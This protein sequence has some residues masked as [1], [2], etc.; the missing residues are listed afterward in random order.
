M[1][2][3]IIM[4]VQTAS[5]VSMKFVESVLLGRKVCIL[6]EKTKKKLYVTGI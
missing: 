1:Y 4:K 3:P 2:D 5:D 6:M